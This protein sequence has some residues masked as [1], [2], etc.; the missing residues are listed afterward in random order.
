MMSSAAAKGARPRGRSGRGALNPV[1][2]ERGADWATET[3]VPGS[4]MAVNL[5]QAAYQPGGVS[6][7]HSI[8]GEETSLRIQIP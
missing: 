1:G 2:G 4:S 5:D 8:G 7:H 3:M 6:G